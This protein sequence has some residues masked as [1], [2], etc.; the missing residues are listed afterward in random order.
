MHT[1]ELDLAVLHGII[2]AL[3][4]PFRKTF[5]VGKAMRG[6]AKVAGG[7]GACWL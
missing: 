1:T 4:R 7:V 2:A 5:T 6:F 3:S